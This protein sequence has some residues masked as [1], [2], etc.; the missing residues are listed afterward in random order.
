MG[1][2][3]DNSGEK[4]IEGVEYP[5]EVERKISV[6]NMFTLS[7]IDIERGGG[8]CTKQSVQLCEEKW[9]KVSRHG[10]GS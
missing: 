10:D 2:R 8:G 3:R 6:V 9:G 7:E 4:Y 5:K 1:G